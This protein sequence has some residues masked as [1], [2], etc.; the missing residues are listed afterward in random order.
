[1]ALLTDRNEFVWTIVSAA[2]SM[3]GELFN[4]INAFFLAFAFVAR[5]FAVYA[6]ILI[7][8]SFVR[9]NR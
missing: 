5:L 3:K 8:I 2:G 4:T 7:V 6:D 9:A 1:M